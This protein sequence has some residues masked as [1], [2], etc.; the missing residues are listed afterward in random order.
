M[1]DQ[2]VSDASAGNPD[3]LQQL[4][5]NVE[6]RLLRLTRKIFSDYA[7]LRRWEQT[8]DVLQNALMRLQRS[9]QDVRPQTSREF[10][11]LAALQIR[12]VL[13]DL[14]R[15]YFGPHGEARHH[16][17]DLNDQGRSRSPLPDVADQ[18]ETSGTQMDDWA[19]F[20]AAV[21]DLPDEENEVFALSWYNG[22]PYR[23]IAELL[24]ISERTVIR[25][26]N[27]ARLK[28][29]TVWAVV[30]GCGHGRSSGSDE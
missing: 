15:H 12:R 24:G 30:D 14:S 16:H 17:T 9:L 10:F 8:D 5:R 18:P 2:L 22:L 20:H 19:R 27:R 7:R 1:L 6:D 4:L 3:A 28:L 13:L 23:S 21:E 29:R 11:G 26:H 25:R